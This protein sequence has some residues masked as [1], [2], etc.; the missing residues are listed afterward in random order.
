MGSLVTSSPDLSV[1]IGAMQSKQVVIPDEFEEIGITVYE[2]SLNVD[3]PVISEDWA[4]LDKAEQE[5]ANAFW[6]L[7][8]KVRFVATRAELKRRIVEL[9]ETTIPVDDVANMNILK[10]KYGKPY[11]ACLKQ[12]IHFNVAHS[13]DKAVLVLSTRF[14]VGVDIE[15]KSL[16]NALKGQLT[17]MV[18]SKKEKALFF[19]HQKNKHLPMSFAETWVAK[20]AVLKALGI[21]LQKSLTD[22]SIVPIW[23]ATAENCDA[24]ACKKFVVKDAPQ[25]WGNI[26]IFSL[27]VNSDYQSIMAL[28]SSSKRFLKH[29]LV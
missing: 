3:K 8:D 29:D 10:S 6:H 15:K 13:V 26:K 27:P 2:L 14:E 12:L 25:E 4:L 17:E 5:K 21:G 19:G 16:V 11:I 24:S 18:Y 1:S 7:A 23:Q 9:C 20:E 22:F 28:T